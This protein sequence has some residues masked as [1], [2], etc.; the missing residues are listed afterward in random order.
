MPTANTPPTSPLNTRWMWLLFLAYD[1]EASSYPATI[2][3]LGFVPDADPT[4]GDQPSDYINDFAANFIADLG[5]WWP[6]SVISDEWGFYWQTALGLQL[7]LSTPSPLV[8]TGLI[9]G[10][11]LPAQCTAIIRKQTGRYLQGIPYF[12]VPFVP[13]AYTDGGQHLNSAGLVALD[14][15]AFRVAQPMTSHGI[16]FT[17]ASWTSKTNRMENILDAFPVARL[18]RSMRRG[19][20]RNWGTGINITSGVWDY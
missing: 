8:P 17:P 4:A 1:T 14:S 11:A 13:R 12:R 9:P 18:G 2:S 16:T 15:L 6:T 7:W 5:T 10:G 20:F 19:A 3:M